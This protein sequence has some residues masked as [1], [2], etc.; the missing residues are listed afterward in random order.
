MRLCIILE[1]DAASLSL[2]RESEQ[3]T[4]APSAPLLLSVRWRRAAEPL[5]ELVSPP[6]SRP[7][8]LNDVPAVAFISLCMRAA[9]AAHS[10]LAGRA[11]RE[12]G[13][14]AALL[15]AHYTDLCH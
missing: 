9:F 5:D 3:R 2:Q 10:H 12:P 1:N 8:A 11:V 13:M 4:S 6:R 14:D 7:P 15:A